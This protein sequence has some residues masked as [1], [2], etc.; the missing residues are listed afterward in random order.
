MWMVVN[1]LEAILAGVVPQYMQ[2]AQPEIIRKFEQHL[3]A[4]KR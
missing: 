1:D 4:E 2:P 3:S